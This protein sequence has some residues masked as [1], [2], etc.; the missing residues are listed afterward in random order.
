MFPCCSGSGCGGNLECIG[1]TDAGQGACFAPGNCGSRGLPCCNSNMGNAGVVNACISELQCTNVAGV[2][3]CQ[4]PAIEM[5][6]QGFMPGLPQL[7]QGITTTGLVTG[8]V[9]TQ[10]SGRKSR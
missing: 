1:A 7:P 3:V 10:L 8:Q 9:S 6:G 2:F 4:V 5:G